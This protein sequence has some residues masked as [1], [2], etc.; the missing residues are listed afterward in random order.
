MKHLPLIGL[1]SARM[2]A[3]GSFLT[4]MPKTVINSDYSDAITYANGLPLIIPPVC[5]Q[6]EIEQF[7][8][9]CDGI[10]IT[11]GKD[12]APLL[13]GEMTHPL[14][15]DYDLEVDRCH[16]ALIRETIKAGKPIL[17]ICRGLQLINIAL[18]GTLYQDL[19][20]QVPGC[21][22]HLFNF[23]RS[24]AVHTVSVA[25]TSPLFHIFGK[26]VLEVNSI[27]HQA[28]KEPGTGV[29]ICA[30]APDGVIEAFTVPD[31]RILAVQWHPEMLLQKNDDMLCLFEAF[32]KQCG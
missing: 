20:S 21:G 30:V 5:S 9:I 14:C 27:H 25:E 26:P 23:I 15:G 10:L 24:D 32:I 16:V 29:E 3:E 7:V 1:S 12:I 22:G 17:G 6:T 31:K 18:G 11:G 28:I 19:P 13:Y 8:E 4:G 2:L